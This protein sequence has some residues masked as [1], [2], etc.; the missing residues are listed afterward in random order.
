MR[1]TTIAWKN[2]RRRPTRTVLTIVGLS[3][4]VAAV[5]ALVGIADG[6]ERSYIDLFKKRGV[7]L[8]VQRANPGND[9]LDRMLDPSIKAKLEKLHGVREVFPG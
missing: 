9:N 7:E 1:F 8:I 2:L 6:F 3:V 4:A 5:V